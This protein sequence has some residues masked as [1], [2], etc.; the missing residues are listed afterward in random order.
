MM[1]YNS[2][3][4]INISLSACRN[5]YPEDAVYFATNSAVKM[6]SEGL[7]QKLAPTYGIN[8]TSLEPGFV[9]I[10]LTETITDEEIKVDL[11][12]MVK[13]LTTLEAEYFAEA[14]YYAKAK[15]KRANIND[16]YIMPTAQK[17]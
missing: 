13:D 7:R 1:K 5:Y 6:F 15:T 12:S 10:E 16:V 3:Y 8:V 14:N 2:G 4:F 9:S 17:E 11:I